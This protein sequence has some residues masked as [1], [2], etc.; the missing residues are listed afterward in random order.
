MRVLIAGVCALWVSVA[1]SQA[2][3]QV[4]PSAERAERLDE[5]VLG[6]KDNDYAIS[7]KDFQL[8]AGKYYRLK[9]T[10][11]GFK[12]YMFRAPELFRNAWI[13]Q[14]VV[15]D[16]EVHTNWIH[17]L[18]FDDQGTMEIFFIPQRGGE[19]PWFVEGFESNGMAGKFVVKYQ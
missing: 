18:E 9:V 12:E 19:Y 13:R 6:T 7:R 2:A 1:V 10:S 5:L 14:V 8:Q 15:N 16:L 4:A 17:G 11:A 3:A